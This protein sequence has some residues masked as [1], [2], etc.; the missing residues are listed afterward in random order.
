MKIELQQIKI[1]DLVEGYV[2]NSESGVVA[3]DGKL[4]VR[5]PYQREFVYKDKQREAVID[6]VLKGFPLNV[7][8]W[9]TR[10]DGTFEVIDGQQRTISICQYINGDFAFDFKYFHNLPKDKQEIIL[11]YELMIYFCTGLESEKLDW[12]RIINIAGE[13]LTDQELLN[14]VYCGT[15]VNDAKKYFSKN[16]CPA[17]NIGSDYLSGSPIR[18]EYLQTAIDWI[19]KGAIEKYMSKHHHEPNAVALWNYF[20]SVIDWVKA[21]F[22]KYRK[23]QKGL[24]WGKLYD[25]FKDKSLDAN[26]LEAEIADLMK[27]EDV[28][29]KS[30]IYDYVLTRKEKYLNLRTFTDNQKRESYE[31]QNGICVKCNDYFELNA[32]EADHI[33]P[34]H[35]GGKTTAENCQMLC[36]DDNRRKSGK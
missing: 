11:N 28:T 30:G 14:A 15:W 7:M 3:Y 31:R 32:M 8:Y 5:P 6:T 12:F 36:I 10:D 27:D 17:Y 1:A 26:K 18:Q 22:P 21:I 9:A 24:N 34:W 20:R 4:D 19:S 33:T 2:D 16:G 25:E 23:E 35:E 29:K 13:K